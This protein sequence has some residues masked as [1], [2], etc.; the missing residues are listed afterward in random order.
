MLMFAFN[1]KKQQN[2]QTPTSGKY[3]SKYKHENANKQEKQR[4]RPIHRINRI[5]NKTVKT[6]VM[7]RCV[8]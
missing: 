6:N 7:V 3:S 1:K 4:N 5:K 8:L 2:K